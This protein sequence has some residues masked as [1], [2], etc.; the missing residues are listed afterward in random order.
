MIWIII[1][2]QQIDERKGKD[3][4]KRVFDYY[5]ISKCGYTPINGEL[6]YA[7]VKKITFNM[8]DGGM[9]C[10][11]GIPGDKEV[12]VD[13]NFTMYE[14]EK[15][16][17]KNSAMRTSELTTDIIMSKL[18]LKNKNGHPYVIVFENND[19]VEKKIG[20]SEVIYDMN[21]FRITDGDQIPKEHYNSREEA[22][23]MN[24]YVVVEADGTKR[25]VKSMAKL[26][27]LNDEQKALLDEFKAV[28]EKMKNAGVGIGINYETDQLVMFNTVGLNIESSGEYEYE[29]K[30]EEER[31]KLFT[32]CNTDKF[33]EYA[34]I[35]NY[36]FNCEYGIEV[37]EA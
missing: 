35:N 28:V 37:K 18:G 33:A 24:D 4:E 20:F 12:E 2:E 36:F 9:K 22:F 34:H 5:E 29:R 17:E 31:G 21:G 19:A 23:E 26:L 32:D 30:S 15:D 10:A 16:Y 8:I 7:Q 1:T 14:S 3:M 11:L 6:V 13:G 27:V 25:V